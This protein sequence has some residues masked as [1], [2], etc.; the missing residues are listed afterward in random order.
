MREHVY[1][2]LLTYLWGRINE[3]ATAF[4]K[5]VGGFVHPYVLLV[6]SMCT[7]KI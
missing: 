7:R 2:I 1:G 6:A 4:S 3:T 5:V